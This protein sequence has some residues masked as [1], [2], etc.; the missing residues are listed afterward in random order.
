[1]HIRAAAPCSTIKLMNA[2]KARW[3]SPSPG[4]GPPSSKMPAMVGA[5]KACSAATQALLL[6]LEMRVEGAA[7]DAGELEQVLDP[8]RLVALLGDDGHQRGEEAL[9]LVAGHLLGGNRRPGCSLR[10]RS[11][12][13]SPHGVVTIAT[14][15]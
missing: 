9:A 8:G 5:T 1:M 11:V 2:S 14:G 4:G 12:P 3:A 15:R 10:S 7:R 6:V 13:A